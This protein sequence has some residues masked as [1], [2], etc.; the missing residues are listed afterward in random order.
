MYVGRHKR[1]TELKKPLKTK[2]R[3]VLEMMKIKR[4]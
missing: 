3:E 1:P 2:I 4:R